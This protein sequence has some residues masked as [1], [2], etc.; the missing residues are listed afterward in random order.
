[1]W[2]HG[3]QIVQTR[4]KLKEEEGQVCHAIDLR[5]CTV[6]LREALEN[7]SK[8]RSVSPRPNGPA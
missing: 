2:A 7:N 8:S 5:G 6:W 4:K 3:F 1:M